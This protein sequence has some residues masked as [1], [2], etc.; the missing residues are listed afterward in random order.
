[1]T[2]HNP[3][4]I[5]EQTKIRNFMTFLGFAWPTPTLDNDEHD[6]SNND[7]DEGD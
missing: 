7:N 6:N 2:F 1:M 4:H 5:H 3:E